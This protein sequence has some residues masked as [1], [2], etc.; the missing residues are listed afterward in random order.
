MRYV[1]PSI[2]LFLTISLP[3]IARTQNRPPSGEQRQGTTS[4]PE[5]GAIVYKNTRYG[6]TFT[7]PASWKGYTI[8]RTRWRSDECSYCPSHKIEHG[9][10]VV[11]RNPRWSR[12]TPWVDIPIIVLTISQS[13]EL[14]DEEISL[15]GA[16]PV[17]PN[18]LGR[19]GRYVFY[20]TTRFGSGIEDQP[21]FDEVFNYILAEHPLHP[22][23][24]KGQPR[25]VAKHTATFAY[26]NREYGFALD[27]PI[28]WKGYI[29]LK[30]AWCQKRGLGGNVDDVTGCPIIVIRHP[31]WA[32]EHPYED[33]PLMVFTHEEWK[34]IEDEDL[35]VTAAPFPPGELGR[36]Q[37]Y[38]F[39][40]PP[41]YN[42]DFSIGWREVQN[43]LTKDHFH[44]F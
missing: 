23:S 1:Y 37:D 35:I 26:V 39:A 22:L 13:E 40:V 3:V 5:S 43:T 15:S 42:Y 6:F 21:G 19:N 8:L 9:V 11:I 10:T 4:S 12:N 27:L 29:V 38:V 20:L 18:E 14:E 30:R 2:L 16:A 31:K 32:A 17:G 41:R 7:L 44:P 33:I 24:M 34:R 28:S 25:H 36:N